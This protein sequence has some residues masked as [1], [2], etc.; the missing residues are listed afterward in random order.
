M[1]YVIINQTEKNLINAT[2][3]LKPFDFSLNIRN[4]AKCILT[5]LVSL[6]LFAMIDNPRAMY[7]FF[8]EPEVMTELK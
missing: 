3:R 8:K 2:L 7:V 4:A 5:F 6:A 1:Y